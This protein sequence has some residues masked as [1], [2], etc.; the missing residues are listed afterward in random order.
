LAFLKYEFKENE[1]TTSRR[2][3]FVVRRCCY[4]CWYSCPFSSSSS[5]GYR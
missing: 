3:E 5:Y 2:R 4:C 1:A